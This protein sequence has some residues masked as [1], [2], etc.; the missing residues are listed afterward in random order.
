[1]VKPVAER[2]S[3]LYPHAGNLEPRV[4]GGD[5]ESMDANEMAHALGLLHGEYPGADLLRAKYGLDAGALRRLRA[6]LRGSALVAYGDT[7]DALVDAVLRALIDAHLCS[8]C[9]GRGHAMIGAL[10]I[11]CHYCGGVGRSA[12]SHRKLQ[13]EIGHITDWRRRYDTMLDRCKGWEGAAIAQ[14]RDR[15]REE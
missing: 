13:A 7:C 15:L 11:E 5:L 2:V 8:V 9:G 1:M 6:R 3:E 12:V 10:R 4:D 14:V